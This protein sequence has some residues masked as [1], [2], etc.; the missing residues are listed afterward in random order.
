[1]RL[2]AFVKVKTCLSSVLF[3]CYFGWSL[4]KIRLVNCTAES[5]NLWNNNNNNNDN[6]D[7]NDD[8][9][10][11]FC[12]DDK[13]SVFKQ[14]TQALCENRKEGNIT[15]RSNSSKLFIT[16]IFSYPMLFKSE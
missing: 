4:D 1:M 14:K 10:A 13:C 6:N 12:I 7:N 3:V 11:S 9:T 16:V 5:F 15:T 2:R 8:I